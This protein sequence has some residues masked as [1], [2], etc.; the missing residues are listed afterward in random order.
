MPFVHKAAKE[1]AFLEDIYME[2]EWANSY[3]ETDNSLPAFRLPDCGFIQRPY[4]EPEL[5]EEEA[6]SGRV[7]ERPPINN[8]FIFI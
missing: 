2:T 4:S 7:R 3:N 5:Q 6:Y 8:P 1:I